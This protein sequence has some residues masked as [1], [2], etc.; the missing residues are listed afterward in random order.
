MNDTFTMHQRLLEAGTLDN[1]R[2]PFLKISFKLV[3]YSSFSS[4]FF[5]RWKRSVGFVAL[6][7]TLVFGVACA[8]FKCATKCG[9]C[10]V[11]NFL[12]IILIKKLYNQNKVYLCPVV[13]MKRQHKT[14]HNVKNKMLLS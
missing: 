7:K 11:N 2:S 10:I 13:A 3:L 8:V 12:E 6:L 5:V 1:L 4:S 9:G 14:Y